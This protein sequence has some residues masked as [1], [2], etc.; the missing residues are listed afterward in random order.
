MSRFAGVSKSMAKEATAGIR[1]AN[2][3]TVNDKKNTN[4][5]LKL[6]TNKNS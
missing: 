3:T 2:I 5:P 4:L 6:R 1:E